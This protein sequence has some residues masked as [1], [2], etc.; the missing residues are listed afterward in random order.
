MSLGNYE[1]DEEIRFGGAVLG[2]QRHICG[3]FRNPDEEYQ[4]LLRFIKEGIERGEKAFH[5]VNPKLYD[6]HVKRL[7][8]VGIDMTE[9][10]KTGQLELCDWEHVY[11]RDGY[12][13]QK[14]CSQCGK[15]H[16]TALCSLDFP[17][18]D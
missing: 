11:F 7:N 16:L 17:G 14:E 10:E 8:S 6:D 3:F 13:D 5:V 18:P 12:F 2:P 15:P 1:S 4:V 9:A